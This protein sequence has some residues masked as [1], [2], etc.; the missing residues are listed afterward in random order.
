[1]TV[2]LTAQAIACSFDGY[3][4]GSKGPDRGAAAD[5]IVRLPNNMSSGRIPVQEVI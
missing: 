1:M 2:Q 3:G 4:R 5:L